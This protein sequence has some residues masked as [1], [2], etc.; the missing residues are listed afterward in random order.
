MFEKAAD[1]AKDGSELKLQGLEVRTD[2]LEAGSLHRSK[3]SI[4]LGTSCLT[5]V[6][7]D[8]VDVR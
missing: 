5:F 8:V 4:A 2:S 7:R 1:L 6:H 3:L